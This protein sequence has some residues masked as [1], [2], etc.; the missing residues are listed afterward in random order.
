MSKMSTRDRRPGV[1]PPDEDS[2][3]LIGAALAEQAAREMAEP[4][5]GGLYIVATPIGNL[6]DMT[7]RAATT[8]ARADAI[9]CEDTRVSRTSVVALC[10]Q[11]AAAGI[12]RAQ[13]RG[14]A[15]PRPGRVGRRARDRAD[16]GRRH[17]AALRSRLQARP[18]RGRRRALSRCAAGRV[19][20]ARGADDVGVADR[21]LLL[22]RLPAGAT[23]RAAGRG[24]SSSQPCRR[25]SCCSNRRDASPRRW[26]TS[27]RLSARARSSSPAN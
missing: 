20:R 13:R 19:G 11:A 3:R 9:L 16:F 15:G 18:R 17:A 1:P 4:L 14:R 26:A 10:D 8:L 2:A 24:W 6:G 5:A 21:Q 7:V 12:P 25:A 23:G 27:P 22:R